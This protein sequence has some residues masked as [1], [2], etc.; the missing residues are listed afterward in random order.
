MNLIR[1]P[2][3]IGSIFLIF[4]LFLLIFG[5]FATYLW[6]SSIYNWE[7]YLNK[8]YSTG[9]ALHESIL[10]KK[11]EIPEG[12]EIHEIYGNPS[13]GASIKN[14]KKYTELPK[15]NFVTSVPISNMTLHIVSKNLRYPVSKLAI[16]SS[17]LPSHQLGEIVRLIATYCGDP[18]IFIN[19]EKNAWKII[20]GDDIWSCEVMP[21]DYRIAS[22]FLI[23]IPLAF[24]FSY[25]HEISQQFLRT[26]MALKGM[27]RTGKRNLFV[28]S[29][30]KELRSIINT[31][32]DYLIMERERLK[33]RIMIL[34]M[35]SHDLGTPATRLKFRAALIKDKEIR[36]KLET[37]I[38][39]MT[40]M[41]ESVLTYTRSE[42]NSEEEIT[43]SLTSLL[44]AI[45]SDYEDQGKPVFF[46]EDV[47]GKV[48]TSGSIF[49]GKRKKFKILKEHD[50]RVLAQVRPYSLQ[51]AIEN[52]IDNSLKYGR[53]ATISLESTSDF[54][55]INIEDEGLTMDEDILNKLVGPF[56]RGPN[57]DIIE[58]VGLG[59]TIVSTIAE[60]HGGNISFQKTRTGIKATLKILRG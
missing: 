9:A 44:S 26:S 59:L 29:G 15:P 38:N 50:R 4:A 48:D 52:L 51:R 49:G 37:D 10:D 16:N 31:L 28:E 30:P 56:K 14:L 47:K 13:A 18:I 20:S 11:R 6:L 12:V 22:A 53:R 19:H 41:I 21:S 36:S 8:A 5:I 17:D 35:V 27:S 2:F 1:R 24:L 3:S 60:Q 54:A 55:Y 33:Q 40:Q 23:L 58:G 7:R 43:M 39:K 25:G 45:V 46:K 34:S 32:N 57:A 42:L